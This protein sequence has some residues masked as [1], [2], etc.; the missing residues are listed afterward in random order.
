MQIKLI[1]C[2]AKLQAQGIDIYEGSEVDF[3]TNKLNE[4]TTVTFWS[5]DF[6]NDVMTLN[7]PD[8]MIVPLEISDFGDVM[9]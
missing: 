5:Y 6:A 9:E 1:N 7:I 8:G 4:L 2:M 3:L